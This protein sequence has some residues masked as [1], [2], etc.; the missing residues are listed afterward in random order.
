MNTIA[1]QGMFLSVKHQSYI[2]K[3]KTQYIQVL[4]LVITIKDTFL[5]DSCGVYYVLMKR[6]NQIDKKVLPR[7]NLS[8]PN[9]LLFLAGL[10]VLVVGYILLSVGPW[11]NPVSRSIAPVVLL[12]GYLVIFPIAIFYRGKRKR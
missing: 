4:I 7:I 12:F 11:D 8:V 9:L 3:Q 5:F 1:L 10:V 2:Y 6:K